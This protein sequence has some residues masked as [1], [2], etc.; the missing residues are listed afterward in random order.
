MSDINMCIHKYRHLEKKK[1]ANIPLCLL[2]LTRSRHHDG[3]GSV[4]ALFVG[5]VKDKRRRKQYG[6][7]IA[8]RPLCR[9]DICDVGEWKKSSSQSRFDCLC[10]PKRELQSKS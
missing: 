2:I 9:S 7:E 5:G 1:R 6:V 8:F 10:Q 3:I 4:S